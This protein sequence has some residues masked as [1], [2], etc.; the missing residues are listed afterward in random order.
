MSSSCIAAAVNA[1]KSQNLEIPAPV[2]VFLPSCWFV[3]KLPL[4]KCCSF[5]LKIRSS[6]S[7][8]QHVPVPLQRPTY[9]TGNGFFTTFL[10]PTRGIFFLSVIQSV[11]RCRNNLLTASSWFQ[12]TANELRAPR[13]SAERRRCF[14]SEKVFN[15]ATSNL[16]VFYL[17]LMWRSEKMNTC[18]RKTKFFKLI[19]LKLSCVFIRIKVFVCDFASTFPRNRGRGGRRGVENLGFSSGYLLFFSW[20]SFKWSYY[21]PNTNPDWEIDPSGWRDW[22]SLLSFTDGE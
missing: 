15:A 4:Q 16:I 8:P 18:L 2:C 10:S 12:Q 6:L 7:K 20:L 17:D 5:T 9:C 1:N 3:S 22:P 19:W 14:T 11:Q 21:L 13:R